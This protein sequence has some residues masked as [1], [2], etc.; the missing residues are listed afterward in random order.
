MTVAPVI[1]I[2]AMNLWTSIAPLIF[3]KL[4]K[5]HCLDC[6]IWQFGFKQHIPSYIDMSDQF[7][8]ISHLDRHT[9]YTWMVHYLQY[10]STWDAQRNFTFREVHHVIFEEKNLGWYLS[11]TCQ[12]I[13]P[14]LTQV[15]LCEEM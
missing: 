8:S 4:V 7:Y 3:F 12:I 9:D 10:I 13:T 1:Y 15:P 14:N 2:L 5:M 11:I 6:V